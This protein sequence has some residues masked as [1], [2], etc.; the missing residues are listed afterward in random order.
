MGLIRVEMLGTVWS[1][2]GTWSWAVLVKKSNFLPH[3]HKNAWTVLRVATFLGFLVNSR[4][5]IPYNANNSIP[6]TLNPELQHVV[7]HGKEN[8]SLVQSTLHVKPP[9]P[10]RSNIPIGV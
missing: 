3:Q 2:Y 7:G 8:V 10:L 5:G 1:L 6:K 4:E 9:L